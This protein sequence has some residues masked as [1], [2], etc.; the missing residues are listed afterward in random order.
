MVENNDA[1]TVGEEKTFSDI[2]TAY[3]DKLKYIV[4]AVLVVLI[5][6]LAGVHFHRRSTTAKETEAGNAIYQTMT[7]LRSDPNADPVAVFSKV[8]TDFAGTAAGDHALIMQFTTA[9]EK[10]Q[11]D[12]AEKAITEFIKRG[13]GSNSML[14]NRAKLALAQ[15]NLMQGKLSEAEAGFRAMA[16]QRFAG[17]Y[18]VA[19]LGLAQTLEQA[20]ETLKDDPEQYRS[21]LMDAEAAYAEISSGARMATSLAQRGFWPAGVV[22]S[23]DFSLAVIKDKL[24]GHMLGVP[25]SM[26]P[27]VP[28]PGNLPKPSDASV[29]PAES[30]PEA[31]NVSAED[32]AEAEAPAE[33][34]ENSEKDVKEEASAPAAPESEEKAGE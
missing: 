24:A 7:D 20:A 16:N 31:G 12:V 29:K 25:S 23:A 6:I 2:M 19:K 5:A 33:T 14:V 9:Y 15:T 32:A 22:L 34:P 28:F 4:I 3:A 21:K 8:S 11:Y 10:E 17:V 13:S 18:P 30:T 1:G 26:K 27:P